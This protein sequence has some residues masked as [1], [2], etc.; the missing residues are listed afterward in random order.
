MTLA[1]CLLGF[2]GNCWWRLIY[3]K[4]RKKWILHYKVFYRPKSVCYAVSAVPCW[5]KGFSS[6]SRRFK[7]NMIRLI[8]TK[9]HHNKCPL[10]LCF[11]TFGWFIDLPNRNGSA[12]RSVFLIIHVIAVSSRERDFTVYLEVVALFNVAI[13]RATWNKVNRI[14]FLKKGNFNY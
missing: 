8:I 2:G 14:C 6:I 3:L 10:G 7:T 1:N 13:T 4:I 11:V 9:Y 12:F 5:L